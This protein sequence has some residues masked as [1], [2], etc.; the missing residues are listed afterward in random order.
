MTAPMPPLV[1]R[2][3]GEPVTYGQV[4]P[5]AHT[6]TRP[7]GVAPHYAMAVRPTP[8]RAAEVE[9]GIPPDS[10][11]EEPLPSRSRPDVAATSQ[12]SRASG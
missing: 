5:F 2:R 1:C 3:C 12:R 6:T 8:S 10:A 11:R 4:L 9:T 7:V